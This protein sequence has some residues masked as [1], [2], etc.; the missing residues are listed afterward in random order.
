MQLAIYFPCEHAHDMSAVSYFDH[1]M[2]SVAKLE[3]DSVDLP[4]V[5]VLEGDA[6]EA[7]IARYYSVS[8]LSKATPSV[9]E[10]SRPGERPYTNSPARFCI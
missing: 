8:P 2:K 6:A 9:L 10:P 5:I 1:Y 4:E 3:T 7:E